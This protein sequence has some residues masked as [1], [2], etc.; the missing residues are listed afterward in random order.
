M[1]ANTRQ[2]R[3]GENRMDIR[4]R[5][6]AR[7]KSI[8]VFCCY[9]REDQPLLLDLKT[10]LMPLQREG[11]IT[12]WADIDINAGE[13]WEKEIHRHLNTAQIILLL[14]SSDFLASE[15]CYSI[16]M[17]RSMERHER[18]EAR[19]IPII[20]R[21]ASW[22]RTP[23]GK[24][25]ALPT[26]ASPITSRKWHDQDEAFY[27]VAEGIREAVEARLVEE[28]RVRKTEEA[29]RARLVEEERMKA[30]QEEA[31]RLAEEERA[32]K[33]AE[34][35]QAR[36]T[37]EERMKA[38]QEEAARLAQEEQARKAAEAR[39]KAQQEKRARKAEKKRV[40]K[41]AEAE[42]AHLALEEWRKVANQFRFGWTEGIT[43]PGQLS[44]PHQQPSPPSQASNPTTLQEHVILPS[45]PD[46]DRS[47]YK[48]RSQFIKESLGY[49]STPFIGVFIVWCYAFALL[50]GLG[51]MVALLT[52]STQSLPWTVGTVALA[53]PLAYLLGYR[54]AMNLLTMSII[55]LMSAAAVFGLTVYSFTLDFDHQMTSQLGFNLSQL[56]FNLPK[57]G[58]NL[59]RMLW[60]GRQVNFGLIIGSIGGVIVGG[61]VF[62]ENDW[63]EWLAKVV[64][65]CT[66]ILI[67]WFVLAIVASI[68]Q[69]GFGFGYGWDISLIAAGVGLVATTGLICSLNVWI[70]AWKVTIVK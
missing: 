24:L 54:K 18:G 66:C 13:E 47:I 67:G 10:H 7:Q 62:D 4:A 60:L 57:L 31:V 15:Y 38:Q 46:I 55:A 14:I 53:T 50:T 52:H 28:E 25:Q 36:L 49:W 34:A 45:Q 63:D 44:L 33:A 20:L 11:L 29:E 8:E 23:L 16:E 39:V 64:G 1:S 58:F 42:Q 19:V 41:A 6:G 9:A 12:L 3:R 22:Q 69:W 48:T 35:E 27:D 21:P 56:G 65:S 32:R 43:S 51:S 30:Q 59:T 2:M 40:R 37:Q 17:Q 68:F 61:A 26:D 70:R 5:E